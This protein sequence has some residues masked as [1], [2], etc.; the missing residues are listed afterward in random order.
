MAD[1]HI[2]HNPGGAHCNPDAKAP[3]KRYV[4]NTCVSV[5]VELPGNR[6][7]RISFTPMTGSGSTFYTDSHVLQHALENHYRYG[8]L[9][10]VDP[11]FRPRHLFHGR[12]CGANPEVRATA[13]IAPMDKKRREPRK[14]TFT[15]YESAKDYLCDKYGFLRTKLRSQK[16]IEEAAEQKGIA[17]EIG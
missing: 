17:L 11:F 5:V 6:S 9:F 1:E 7:R 8:T 12:H 10:R 13:E 4:A 2:P 14:M 3:M 15:D 16:A